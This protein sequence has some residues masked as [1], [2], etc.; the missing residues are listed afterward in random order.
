MP[1]IS[2]SRFRVDAGWED[3][4]HLSEDQKRKMLAS[5]PPY[6]RDARSRGIP[7][8]GEGAIYDIPLDEVTC[9]PFAIPPDW[10]R[11]Y[12]LD[13]GWNWTAAVWL[14][15]NPNDGSMYL[16][17]DYKP[18]AGSPVTHAAAIKA[19]GNLMG[20]VDPSA[21]NTM[22]DGEQI[23][24]LYQQQGLRLVKANNAVDAGISTV[25]L[26]LAEGRLKIFSTCVKTLDEYRRYH[27]KR[28][29]DKD[30]VTKVKIVKRND[31][32]MDAMRYAIMTW[33]KIA[34]IPRP[35]GRAPTGPMRQHDEVAGL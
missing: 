29:T 10:R 32:L 28:K 12:G 22:G 21:N 19:R 18:G 13:V 1:E 14:A 2:E 35:K 3:A 23:M 6:L 25:W 16:Y 8:L 34:A 4:P 30:G 7:S 27:R 15:E 31:H 11:G 17:A 9:P 24:A 26:A 5:T 33:D 20:A